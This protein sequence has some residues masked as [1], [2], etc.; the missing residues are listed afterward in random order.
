MSAQRS[1]TAL[2]VVQGVMAVAH[3][4][5]H[6]A[7]TVLFWRR[8]HLYPING[9][10]PSLA[11]LFLLVAPLLVVIWAP[12][13][14]PC[15]AYFFLQV[16]LAPFLFAVIVARLW[17][18]LCKHEIEADLLRKAKF[19]LTATS[20]ASWRPSWFTRNYKYAR[21]E[22]ATKA[23]L[24]LLALFVCISVTQLFTF[25]GKLS[26][27]CEDS[28]LAWQ[29]LQTYVVTA[30]CP[31]L[32]LALLFVTWRLNRHKNDGFGVLLE[33]KRIAVAM[34]FL[35]INAMINISVPMSSQV[36]SCAPA[37][38]LSACLAAA[39]A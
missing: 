24:A 6:I 31:P 12:I 20:G 26:D 36:C 19:Q 7:G 13:P 38:R 18:L 9:R 21:T 25:P 8:R 16:P 10:F 17:V 27:R 39:I 15:V 23:C 5:G 1:S 3:V 29:R 28:T 2:V 34:T 35:M 11:M 14:K 33:H 22:L 4:T 30:P 32:L 37:A